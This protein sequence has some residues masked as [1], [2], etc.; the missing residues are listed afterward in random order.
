MRRRIVGILLVVITTAIAGQS[1]TSARQGD[2]KQC[3]PRLV[4]KPDFPRKIRAAKGEKSIKS[5]PV[6]SF[7]ILDSGD[8]ANVRL[9]RSSGV[10][11]LDQ[12]ALKWIGSAR[13]NQ[14]P[15]CGVIE[16]FVTVVVDMR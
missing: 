2:S 12:K 7:E 1:G 13:Y 4:H 10:A 15:G 16:S 11:D 5:A 6:I 9:K 8:I 3:T 14:R